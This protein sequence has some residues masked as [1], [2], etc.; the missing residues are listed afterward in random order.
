MINYRISFAGADVAVQAQDQSS[1]ELL[2]LLF[3][4]LL[5]PE[6]AVAAPRLSLAFAEGSDTFSVFEDAVSIFE[7]QSKVQCAAIL[8][9]RVIFH[10][11]DETG[12]GAALHCGSVIGEDRLILIPGQ[13]GAGKSTLVWWLTNC[14]Y[15]YLTDELIFIDEQAAKP[16]EF[17]TRPVCL[18][19]GALPL[20]EACATNVWQ[21]ML[22]D[23]HGA[24]LTPQL[25]GETDDNMDRK[26]KADR[27]SVP[28][29]P[30]LVLLP[31]YQAGSPLEIERI[32]TARL[33]GLLMQCH[34]NARNLEDHGF[35]QIVGLARTT[36]AYLLRYDSFAGLAEAIDRTLT[37]SSRN[38]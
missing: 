23:R 14:G 15:R 38:K 16:I 12:G 7:G 5:T 21:D 3:H 9:D 22:R 18:K 32:S 36:P 10:L 8:Y 35:R 34:A 37:I 24:L 11:L 31:Q 4:G 17:F 26:T 28:P 13:S 29:H 6:S 20:I 25:A 2:V 1:S 33:V 27:G 19:S 30:A